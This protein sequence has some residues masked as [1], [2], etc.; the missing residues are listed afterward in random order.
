MFITELISARSIKLEVQ[1]NDD[2]KALKCCS[3]G[4]YI[5]TGTGSRFLKQPQIESI[6]TIVAMATG[7]QLDKKEIDELLYKY[8]RKH[9][10]SPGN[11]NWIDEIESYLAMILV[12]E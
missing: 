4:A 7:R 6:Q 11:Q 3:S 5:L 12:I 8:R 9:L 2:E 1:T 10:F